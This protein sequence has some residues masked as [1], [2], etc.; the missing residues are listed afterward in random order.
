MRKT[1]KIELLYDVAAAI[2]RSAVPMR[3]KV[4]NY[5][6]AGLYHVARYW[7]YEIDDINRMYHKI[8]ELVDI[9]NSK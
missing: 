2:S 8:L 4:G 7:E 5:K 1:E 9:I 3:E 6:D